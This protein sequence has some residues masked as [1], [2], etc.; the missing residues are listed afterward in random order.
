MSDRNIRW[1]KYTLPNGKDVYLTQRP[2]SAKESS[3]GSFI[4]AKNPIIRFCFC[5]DFVQP[6]L[7]VPWHWLPWLPGKQIPIENVFAF[8][9]LMNHYVECHT[10]PSIWL[11]CDSSSMRAPTYFGLY[12]NALFPDKVQEI[13]DGMSVNKNGNLKYAKYSL[14]NK[15]AETSF[16]MDPGIKKL[17]E[18]WQKGGEEEAHEYLDRL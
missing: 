17:I 11:H 5:D 1:S 8:I 9:S 6:P 12:L 18:A 14:A 16:K 10:G 2:D 13:C 7:G 3:V 4:A 15:Y